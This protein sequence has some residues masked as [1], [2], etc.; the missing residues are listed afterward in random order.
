MFGNDLSAVNDCMRIFDNKPNGQCPFNKLKKKNTLKRKKI[1]NEDAT[2]YF[3]IFRKQLAQ[4]C[5]LVERKINK[6]KKTIFIRLTEIKLKF[7]S[8]N[9]IDYRHLSRA[10]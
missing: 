8:M 10:M 6:R 1:A 9:L 2:I 5:R 4:K 7:K 3:Q